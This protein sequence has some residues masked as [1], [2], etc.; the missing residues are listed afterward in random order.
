MAV[1]AGPDIVE[2]GLVLHLDAANPRS[3]PGTGT[4]WFDLS[5]NNNNGTLTNG[6]SYN[7]DQLGNIVF[8]GTNDE[9]IAT[10]IGL[11]NYTF[12]FF[13]KATGDSLAGANRYNTLIGY[14]GS[15][16]LLYHTNGTL[17]AQ[18]GTGNI[19]ST[20]TAPRNNWNHIVFSYNAPNTTA[21]WYIN[22]TNAGSTSGTA[23]GTWTSTIYIGSYNSNNYWMN[24]NISSVKIYNRA[25]VAEEIQQ[26]FN[27]L[28]GRFGI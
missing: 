14:D 13:V 25:L 23:Q 15:R 2:N 17:L 3:Y 1:Y 27:A 24:G 12:E 26:N 4:G 7:Q 16:R 8:D 18:V 5:G 11:T 9:V 28:R 20:T 10:N 19:F 22:G 21:T 6:P